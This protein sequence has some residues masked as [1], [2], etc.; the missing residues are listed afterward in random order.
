MKNP[1]KNILINAALFLLGCFLAFILSEII[2]RI[3]NPLPLPYKNSLFLRNSYT[4]RMKNTKGLNDIDENIVVSKN[5]CGFRG[6]DLGSQYKTKI[7]FVGGSTTECLCVSDGKDWPGLV[8]EKL[9]KI[10]STVWVNNAGM[11][12]NSTYGHLILM[13]DVVKKI[14]LDYACFMV[15]INDARICTM[16]KEDKGMFD[17]FDG[18]WRAKIL[19][20]SRVVQTFKFLMGVKEAYRWGINDQKVDFHSIEILNT[21][22]DSIQHEIKKLQKLV[23]QS[24]EPYE[25]RVQQLIDLCNSHHI[26]PVFIAQTT[27]FGFWDPGTG[28]DLG[29]FMKVHSNQEVTGIYGKYAKEQNSFYNDLT[30]KICVRNKV[31]FIE[32]DSLIRKD[33]GNFYDFVHLNN[34]GCREVAAIISPELIRILKRDNKLNALLIK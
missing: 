24:D 7:L 21:N 12:G 29:G 31:D 33:S 6:P 23:I 8:G 1:F 28:K 14:K 13:E 5:H 17:Y 18:G 26:K 4:I 15:G 32:L 30:R 34:K 10:D 3:Y 27:A 20:T 19:A 9:L 25:K 16:R 11:G 2:L 22:N